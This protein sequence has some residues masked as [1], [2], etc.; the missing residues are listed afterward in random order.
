MR[1]INEFT[2]LA[3]VHDL[4][5]TLDTMIIDIIEC[6]YSHCTSIITLPLS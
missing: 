6:R 4:S 3:V 2:S 1:S 5:Q